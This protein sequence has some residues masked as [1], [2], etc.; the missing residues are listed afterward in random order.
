MKSV[1][2]NRSGRCEMG[3]ETKGGLPN[4]VRRALLTDVSSFAPTEVLIR[5]NTSCQSDEYIAHRV[6]LIPFVQGGTSC[7]SL[8]LSVSGR[9]ATTSDLRGDSFRAVHEIP[10]VRLNDTQTLD[11]DVRFGR[12]TAAEHAKFAQIGP[13]SYTRGDKERTA[14]GFETINNTCALDYLEAALQTLV[15]SVDDAKLQVETTETETT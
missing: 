1:R 5:R 8:S 14:M 3:F 13:V 9:T 11:L 6:G 4:A 2:I 12:G 10:L 15:A 7:T